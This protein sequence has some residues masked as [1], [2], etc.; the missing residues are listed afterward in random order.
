MGSQTVWLDW[1]TFTFTFPSKEQVSFNFTVHSDFLAQ[2]NNIC[3]CSHFFPICL[4]WSDGTIPYHISWVLPKFLT[5]EIVRHNAVVVVLSWNNLFFS[6]KL[7]LASTLFTLSSN[8]TFMMSWIQCM[9]WNFGIMIIKG[10]HS[11]F[12][13]EKQGK[14]KVILFPLGSCF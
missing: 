5:H 3:H 9:V 6:E 4:P 13:K 14:R 7:G 11:T 10:S 8:T 12:L 1:A 2:V